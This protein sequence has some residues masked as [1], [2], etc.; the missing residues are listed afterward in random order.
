[1][2]IPPDL[3]QPWQG[4]AAN[5]RADEMQTLASWILAG[6]SGSVIGLSGIGKTNLL[7]FLSHRP[8]VLQA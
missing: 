4:Y 8:D 5:Y 3:G 6:A 7:N 1:M 2:H